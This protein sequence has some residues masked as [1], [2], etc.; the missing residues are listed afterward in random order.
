MRRVGQSGRVNGD[1]QVRVVTSDDVA[2]MADVMV[3]RRALYETFSPVFWRPAA[4]AREVHEPYLASCVASDRYLGLRTTTG[5]VLGE[6][7][8]AGSPPWWSEVPIGFFDDFAVVEDGAWTSD[9]RTLLLAAWSH[10]R[11]RGA[12]A[13]R[14]V[15]AIRDTS[16][17]AMLEKLGLTIGESWYI[18]TLNNRGSDAPTFGPVEADGIDALVIPAPPVYDPGG[19]VLL[20][21]SLVSVDAIKWLPDVAAEHGAVLAILPTKPGVPGIAEAADACGFDETTRYYVG[22]PDEDTAAP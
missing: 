6:L 3:E 2:W 22:Q 21:T 7:Q 11:E 4:N 13:V 18:R 8:T 5:F 9:G 20:V 15:T 12:E 17:V 14:V 19:A 10:L 16:K 1:Q